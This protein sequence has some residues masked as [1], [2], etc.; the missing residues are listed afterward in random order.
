MNELP[1]FHGNVIS[2]LAKYDINVAAE[3]IVCTN[4]FKSDRVMVEV[5]LNQYLNGIVMIVFC[6]KYEN[7]IVNVPSKKNTCE[8]IVKPWFEALYPDGFSESN[9]DEAK[10]W[11]DLVTNGGTTDLAVTL[12]DDTEDAKFKAEMNNE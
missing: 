2:N 7:A 4:I 9:S 11:A 10:Y 3:D 6:G 5:R 8:M 12:S 1:G